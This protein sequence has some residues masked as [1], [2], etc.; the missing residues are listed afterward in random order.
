MLW[1]ALYGHRHDNVPNLLVCY[2]P[3]AALDDMVSIV[4]WFM[5]LLYWLHDQ[6]LGLNLAVIILFPYI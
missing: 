1:A 4:Q 6:V 5:L 3:A 2:L